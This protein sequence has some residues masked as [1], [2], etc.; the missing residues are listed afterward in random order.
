[1]NIKLDLSKFKHK[2]SEEGATTLV[3]ET[4]GHCITLSHGKLSKEHRAQLEALRDATKAKKD[5]KAS[6]ESKQEPSSVGAKEPVMMASGGQ[7]PYKLD[8]AEDVTKESLIPTGVSP[9]T[10]KREEMN[11]FSPSNVLKPEPKAEA[12]A[13]MPE[14]PKPSDFVMQKA[15]SEGLNEYARL[16]EPQKQEYLKKI[17]YGQTEA[18]PAQ[19][20]ETIAPAQ[21]QPASA[22]M[23]QPGEPVQPQVAPQ[24]QANIQPSAPVAPAAPQPVKEM[25]SQQY[26]SQ[27]DAV[28][29]DFADGHITPKT[30]SSMFAEKNTL[31]KISTIFGLLVS[32][33]GSGMSKQPNMLMEMMDKE[34][35]RDLEA[36]K[37]TK[38]NQMNFIQLAQQ[39]IMNQAN[40]DHLRFEDKVKAQALAQQYAYMSAYDKLSRQAKSMPEGPAKVNALNALA[41]IAQGIND[42]AL[43]TGSM[44]DAQYE[45]MQRS[46]QLG[47]ATKGQEEVDQ[48]FAKEYTKFTTSGAVNAKNSMNKIELLVREMKKDQGV[49]EAGGGRTATMLP[50]VLRSRDAIRRR[51]SARNLANATLKELFGGQLSDAERESAAREYYNDALDNK[52]NAKIL[53]GKLKELRSVYDNKLKQ[54]KYFEQ[55]KGTLRGFKG[56]E[57][58]GAD[59]NEVKYRNGVPYK[60]DPN[61]NQYVKVK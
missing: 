28:K 32:G 22:P 20:P 25:P 59:F 52:E 9:E 35:A 38:S 54:S 57:A 40:I 46:P 7:V 39:Q 31:G 61:T 5:A 58:Q 53:E 24:A 60:L 8:E 12:P 56:S 6:K 3:H 43:M 14:A 4:D 1:M 10:M 27:L 26:L 29:Q 41:G 55:N 11:A 51:D 44:L 19:A 23:G 36:Q 17:G 15:G 50:D 48:E 34:I 45:A 21:T 37:A 33:A 30:Y 13:P 18:Q 16:D 2:S 49:G 47:K 42:K